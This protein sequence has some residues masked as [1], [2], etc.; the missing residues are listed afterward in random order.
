MNVKTAE[1]KAIENMICQ[2]KAIGNNH[3]SLRK[4]ILADSTLNW[5][6]SAGYRVY[7]TRGKARIVW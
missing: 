5:L 2:E 3:L 4:V 7:Y 6:R 1:I